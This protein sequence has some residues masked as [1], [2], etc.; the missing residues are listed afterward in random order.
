VLP[1]SNFFLQGEIVQIENHVATTSKG[2]LWTGR[3]FSALAVLFLLFD[4]IIKI[5]KIQPVVEGFAKLGYPPN[6]AVPIGIVLLVCVVLYIIPRT[7]VLGAILLTGYLGG[8]VAT[9]VRAGDPL[10]SHVLFPIYFGIFI[11]GGLYLRDA[12][13]RAL[14]P[15]RA[16]N[17]S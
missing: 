8:A 12:R 14:I 3:V 17:L 6:V 13:L 9:H 15:L 2:S 1:E 4:S 16:P 10:F 7:S 11:W 5:I